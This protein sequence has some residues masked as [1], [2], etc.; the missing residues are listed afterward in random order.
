MSDCATVFYLWKFWGKT[1]LGTVDRYDPTACCTMAG[2]TCNGPSVTDI[3][4]SSELLSGPI[5]PE[6]GNLVNLKRL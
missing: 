4:W 5:P 3:N 2:V 6:I 1:L